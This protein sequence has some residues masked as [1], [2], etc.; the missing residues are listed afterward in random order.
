MRLFV[1]LTFMTALSTSACATL[2]VKDGATAAP[3]LLPTP[4]AQ[5]EQRTVHCAQGGTKQVI[6]NNDQWIDYSRCPG[7]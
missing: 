6:C 3:V 2:H 7:E 5:N 4:C 1:L